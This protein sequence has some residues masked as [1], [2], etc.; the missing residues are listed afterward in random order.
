MRGVPWVL[1]EF[2][3]PN[4]STRVKNPLHVAE[5]AAARISA[6]SLL[7]G[8]TSQVLLDGAHWLLAKDLEVEVEDYLSR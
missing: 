2:S 7:P 4:P 8:S 1:E 6:R 5:Y 3:S